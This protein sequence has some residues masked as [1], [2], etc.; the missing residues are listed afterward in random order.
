[1]PDLSF[2]IH[3]GV[4]DTVYGVGVGNW[5]WHFTQHRYESAG[6]GVSVIQWLGPLRMTA[7]FAS[8]W[9]PTS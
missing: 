5:P 6:G 7:N 3:I 4:G 1:M 8:K 2:S 9:K